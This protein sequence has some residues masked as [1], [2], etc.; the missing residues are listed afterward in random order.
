MHQREAGGEALV[1]EV[2][3]ER[4]ELERR[5][6]ALVDQ[7]AG[8]ERREV[9]ADLALGALAQPEGLAVELDPAERDALVVGVRRLQEQLLEGRCRVPCQRA[10]VRGVGRDIPPTENG[11]A[12]LRGDPGDPGL[13]LGALGLVE[14]QERHADGV[15]SHGRQIETGDR[16]QERVGDLR[17][18][19]G[20]VSGSGIRPHRT[21]V[22]EVTE[23]LQRRRDDVVPR[24]SAQRGD[25]GETAGILL[26]ARVVETLRR[27]NGAE[28]FI[29]CGMRHEN[30]P[31]DGAGDGTSAAQ[32]GRSVGVV[33]RTRTFG[34]LRLWRER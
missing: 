2:G 6:H 32:G 17:D 31:H 13:Q 9:R 29:G 24:R 12:L 33:S 14:G 22:L 7:G 20:P 8:R 16:A 3:V 1:A 25:H 21:A 4:L 19:P 15:A 23:R 10:Q 34:W 30:R 28:P 27:G 26:A 5:D 18:D 11:E